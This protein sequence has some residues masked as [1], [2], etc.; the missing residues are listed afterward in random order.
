MRHLGIYFSRLNTNTFLVDEL[1][2]KSHQSAPYSNARSH[3]STA[4]HFCFDAR[5]VYPFANNN[6]GNV[7]YLLIVYRFQSVFNRNCIFTRQRASGIADVSNI[8]NFYFLSAKR[9]MAPTM[10]TLIKCFHLSLFQW[11]GTF[12]RPTSIQFEIVI[13]SFDFHEKRRDKK[14]LREEIDELIRIEDT[15]RCPFGSGY[16]VSNL[17]RIHFLQKAVAKHTPLCDVQ[18]GARVLMFKFPGIINSVRNEFEKLLKS[19]YK[20]RKRFDGN[21][22]QKDEIWKRRYGRLSTQLWHSWVVTDV[23]IYVLLRYHMI[24]TK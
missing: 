12:E 21:D 10:L 24:K 2:L 7:Y 22:R 19:E 6:I 14:C 3:S 17:F 5:R 16:S 15:C 4:L 1:S 9:T 11:M 18:C 23:V 20:I 8:G 13:D